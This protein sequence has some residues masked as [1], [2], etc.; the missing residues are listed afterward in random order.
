MSEHLLLEVGDIIKIKP[1][2][3][4][5]TLPEGVPIH[6]VRVYVGPD[7]ERQYSLDWPGKV[8]TISALMQ[9]GADKF[10]VK[11]VRGPGEEQA[12]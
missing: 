11:L 1:G 6:V 5:S 12:G 2:S 4:L 10:A 3:L 7:G 9:Y 8:S